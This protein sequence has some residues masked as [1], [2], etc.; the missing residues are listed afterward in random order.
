MTKFFIHRFYVKMV[1]K[2]HIAEVNK[3]MIYCSSWQQQTPP[4]KGLGTKQGVATRQ[5]NKR[6]WSHLIFKMARLAFNGWFNEEALAGN[7]IK[8]IA[9]LRGYAQP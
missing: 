7:Q 6:L 9:T 3:A 2:I 1:A 4:D 8:L 5:S